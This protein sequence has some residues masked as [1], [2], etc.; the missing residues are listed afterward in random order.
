MKLQF[1]NIVQLSWLMLLALSFTIVSCGDDD[2]EPPSGGDDPIASFQ[3]EDTDDFLT[4]KF[5]NFSQ[6]ASTYAW[7]FGD[8]NT[9][10]DENPSHTYASAGTYSVVLTASNSDGKS[11]SRTEEVNVVDP[12]QQLTILAGADS[13]TWYIQREGIVA[14]IGPEPGQNDWWSFGGVTPLAERPCV[15][16]DQYIFHRDGKFEFNSNGT[17]FVDGTAN[18]GWIINGE[19][20]EGCQDES[21]AGVWGD[22]SDREAFGNGGDYTFD[23][24]N[25]NSTLTLNGA[26][27]YIGL[28]VKTA[29]GDNNLPIQMKTFMVRSLAQGE[30]ADSMKLSIV[31]DGFAW[32]FDLVS[33]HN[34]ADLPDIPTDVPVF[35]EDLPDATPSSLVNTFSG[36]AGASLDTIISGSGIVYG[37]DDPADAGAAKVGEFLRTGEQYQELKLQTV[38]TK[39]DI[40]FS[41]L[42]TVSLDVYM[43]SSNDYSGMLTRNVIIGLAD[44][45]QTQQWWTDQMEYHAMDVAMDEWVTLTFP[46]DNPSYVAKPE[47]AA[48]PFGRNDYDMV[49]INIGGGGHTDTG[50]FYVRN[51]KFE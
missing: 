21:A 31:G 6:N 39:N 7:N 46:L 4:K 29:D 17:L 5:S 47:T 32:N 13:R 35:G 14:G 3:V 36:E 1:K 44:A 45:S 49:Y 48:N 9:S 19:D 22:N 41:N 15:L 38:P 10:T 40:N 37:V 43:P 2:P 25:T 27:A 12:N 20:T 8:G 33:Y 30:I 16:D 18:G 51:L 23:L 28:A 50:T 11:A 24:D 42:S 26:G 34:P